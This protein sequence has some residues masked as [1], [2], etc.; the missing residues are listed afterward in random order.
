MFTDPDKI[1]SILPLREGMSVADLGSGSGILT[2]KI[3]E[4]IRGGG[5][6]AQSS[7]KVYALDVQKELLLRMKKEAELKRIKNI[8]I[9][10]ADLERP[11]GSHLKDEAV[12]L[13]IISNILFQVDDK[14]TFLDEVRRIVKREGQVALIDWSDSFNNLG[15]TPDRIITKET[16]KNLMEKKGFNFVKDMELSDHHWGSIFKK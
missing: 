1:V 2:L 6:Y 8:E 3:A 11:G 5:E 9:I 16:G 14:N 10:W 7:G 12:D 4:R 15:P 13:A